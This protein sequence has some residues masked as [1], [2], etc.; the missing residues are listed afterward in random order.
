MLCTLVLVLLPG[1][2]LAAGTFLDDDGSVHESDIEAVA[3][4]GITRGCNP[5]ANDRFCPGDFVTRGQMAAFLVRGLH[6]EQGAATF[7]DDDDSIF[8]S[9]I[10]RLAS[11][12]ITV[13]CNPPLND[14]FCPEDF[15]TR[16]QMAAFLTRAFRYPTPATDPFTDTIG[17]QFRVSAASLAEAGVTVG[18]NPP[19]ND[20]YCPDD[21]VTRAQMATFLARAIGLEPPPSADPTW[22]ETPTVMGV[23][24][25]TLEVSPTG[26]TTLADA[27]ADARPGDDI[28]LGAGTY[29]A[30]SSLVLAESGESHA[31]ISIRGAPGS[32]PVID[33][34][35][36]GELRISGSHVLLENVRVIDG[37]GNNIHI[38]PGE[39]SISHVVIRD[40]IVADLRD[41]PGAAI[42]VNRNN[43]FAAGVSFVYVEDS[44]LS[45]SL[46]NAVVDGVG[47]SYAVVRGSD[48]HDSEVGSHGIFFKG[49]S[50]HVLIEK[51]V[52]R[53]IR[54]NAALQLGGNTG[55]EFF[56]PAWPDWEGV[57][58]VARNNL[59]ADFDDSAVE[60]RGVWGGRVYHNTIVTRSSFAVFR[61]S[62]GNTDGGGF[63]TNLD[64]DIANNLVV[65]LGGDPQYARN[66]CAGEDI[67]FG[68]QGWFGMF[69]NSGT[70][71]PLVPLFPAP[72]DVA[73]IDVA[74]SVVTPS[75]TGLTGPGDARAR[76]GPIAESAAIG[77]GAY[78]GVTEDFDGAIRDEIAPTLGAIE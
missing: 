10:E 51:N 52:I 46:A 34:D 33:L 64:I 48:I 55:V 77:A 25:R 66:D 15:V 18:C 67:R 40:V 68:R 6:L 22:Y 42:K 8:E 70:P 20:R 14:R 37:S 4:A 76:F 9:D 23:G 41:G 45:G 21:F 1:T 54:Q 56:D 71:T 28:V 63:S 7:I 50:D 75:D 62:C 26:P 24:I 5:P 44:D 74:G 16:G 49:G 47:V 72:G 65:G 59:I 57:D 17:S 38:A 53:G 27:L 32:R 31:W 73:D 60:I 2:A 39:Q 78:V 30:T 36:A 11:A 43:P 58:Q 13:G 12:G 3:A 35:G 29:T 19:T 61:L 69:H